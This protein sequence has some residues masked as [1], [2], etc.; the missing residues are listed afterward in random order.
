MRFMTMVEVS[1]CTPG[2]V[3]SSAQTKLERE[4]KIRSECQRLL[5]ELGA[6]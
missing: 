6:G 3:A 5:R 1:F 4:E 2:R